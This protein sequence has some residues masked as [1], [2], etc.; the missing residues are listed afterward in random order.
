MH[1]YIYSNNVLFMKYDNNRTLLDNTRVQVER[2]MVNTVFV[3]IFEGVNKTC[4]CIFARGW[5]SH[6]CTESMVDS[7]KHCLCTRGGYHMHIIV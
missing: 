7:I 4:L 6:V 5:I 2:R 3:H 1:K